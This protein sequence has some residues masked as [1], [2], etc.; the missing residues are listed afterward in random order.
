MTNPTLLVLDGTFAIHRFAPGTSIP[1]VV[2][3]SPF[4]VVTATDEELSVV[5]R[6][7]CW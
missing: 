3:S 6:T 4:Y 1:K 5:L 2:F 7:G